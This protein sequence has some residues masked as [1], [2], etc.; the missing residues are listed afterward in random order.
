M[1]KE[2]SIIL[3]SLHLPDSIHFNFFENNKQS[4][5]ISDNLLREWFSEIPST[6]DWIQLCWCGFHYQ[7]RYFNELTSAYICA[8]TTNRRWR[9]GV[10]VR[11]VFRWPDRLVKHRKKFQSNP[12]RTETSKTRFSKSWQC[13][14]SHS[15]AY[16]VLTV[17]ICKIHRKLS[18]LGCDDKFLLNVLIAIGAWIR[19]DEEFVCVY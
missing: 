14:T 6:A 12:N 16:S 9:L 3:P 1:H 4:L 5:L 19:S 10:R 8:L 15:I 11:G 13:V 7:A 2:I 17:N 18:T